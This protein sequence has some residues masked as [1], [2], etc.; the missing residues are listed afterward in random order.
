M[1][2]YSAVLA[3]SLVAIAS[4]YGVLNANAQ[5]ICSDVSATAVNGVSLG[6][7]VAGQ[8]YSYQASGVVGYNLDGCQSDPDGN[9]VAGACSPATGDDSFTCP[10]LKA[11]SLVGKVNGQCL[12]LGSSGTFVAP[13]SGSLVLYFN[14]SIYGDNSGSFSACVTP[15][16]VQQPC[17]S[18]SGAASGGVSFGNVVMGQSYNYQ[19][20]GVIGYN[21]DGCQ[22]DPDG[23][24]VAGACSPAI[25]DD[26]FT[27]PGL[28]AFSLV[29]KLNGQCLQLG[30]SGTFVA[31]SSGS[32]ILYFNDSIYSD[33]SGSWNVC[34]AAPS[35]DSDLDGV[36]DDQ[37]ECPN[38]PPGAI[39]NSHGCSIDQLVPCSGPASGGTWKNH[40]QYV[41]AFVE[42]STQFFVDG[43]ITPDQ[44]HAMVPKA[45]HSACGKKRNNRQALHN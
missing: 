33:N 28:K 26:S 45:A 20:S 31:P 36:P 41:S 5:S 22:S 23:N 39:V 19:A 27:C 29:A 14:D 35:D 18:V 21:L 2:N 37:D 13:S 1:R 4:I 25:G 9:I 6:N 17:A 11:F 34:L 8:T 43:L 15:T 38:T 7:V 32:L 42:V 30:S 3:A 24:I 16:Q 44:F 10:G 12:Q 40:G